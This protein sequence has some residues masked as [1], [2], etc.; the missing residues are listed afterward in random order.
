MKFVDAVVEMRACFDA[1]KWLV[2]SKLSFRRAW[3]TCPRADWMLWL[4]GKMKHRPGWPNSEEAL[5]AYRQLAG[6]IHESITGL[7]SADVALA[8]DHP[9]DFGE[10]LFAECGG[11]L[12]RLELWADELR[13]ILDVPKR[14]RY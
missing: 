12:K 1:K 13:Q 11:N 4:V 14:W 7:T 9:E 10:H 8:M 5:R 2:A 6:P 3:E